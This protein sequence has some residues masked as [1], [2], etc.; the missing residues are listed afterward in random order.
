MSEQENEKLYT[1]GFNGGYAL[2]KSEPDLV[3]QILSTENDWNIFVQG[4]RDGRKEYLKEVNGS[5]K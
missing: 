1:K 2:S 4:I 5:V 3:N